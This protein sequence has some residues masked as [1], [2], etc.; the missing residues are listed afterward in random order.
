MQL[1]NNQNCVAQTAS[2]FNALEFVNA[3]VTPERESL[4]MPGTRLKVPVFV[5]PLVQPPPREISSLN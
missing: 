3:Q 1:A 5:S 2:Q 4:A